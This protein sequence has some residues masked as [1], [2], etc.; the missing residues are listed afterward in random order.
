MSVD[1]RLHIALIMASAAHRKSCRGE[2]QK[3]DLSEGQPKVLSALSEREGYLQKDLASQ[4]HVEP[5]T[6]TIILNNMEKKGLI[7]KETAHVSGGKRAFAIYLTDLGRDIA[8]K[9]NSIVVDIENIGLA[10]F[11]DEEK[12]QFIDY[13]HRFNT[14]LA[15]EN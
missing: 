15:P 8:V 6:M 1:K 14:N 2:F 3:L 12:E 13:L 4:C 10:G 11:S 7:R 9:V 5:A